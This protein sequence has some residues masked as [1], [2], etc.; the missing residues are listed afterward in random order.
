MHHHIFF[1]DA[2]TWLDLFEATKEY[3]ALK[4]GQLASPERFVSGLDYMPAIFRKNMKPRTVRVPVGP[5]LAFRGKDGHGS[6]HVTPTPRLLEIIRPN[7]IMD[8]RERITFEA[9]E[10]DDA[11]ILIVAQHALIL[12]GLWLCI[13]PDRSSIPPVAWPHD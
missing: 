6:A 5:Y 4:A 13:L 7:I 2:K 1:P 9:I 3:P 12:S 10:R 11:T 8:E